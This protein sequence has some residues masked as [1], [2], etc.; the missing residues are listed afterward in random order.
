MKIPS[1][2]RVANALLEMVKDCPR[3]TWFTLQRFWGDR[4]PQA[5]AALTYTA[6]LALVPLT[7]ITVGI[8]SAFPAFDEVMG[9]AQTFAFDNFVP[10]VGQ[11]VQEHLEGF[12]QNAGRLTTLGVLAL[13]ITAVLLLATIEAAFNNI[14]RVRESRP[15]LVRL[16]S[17]WAILTLTPLLFGASISVT[18]QLFSG[19]DFEG[20]I[21]ML[22]Y[23]RGA[24]PLLF[25]W[26]GFSA[27]Y[28]IIPNRPIRGGDA[29]VGGAVAAVLLELS[30]SGFAYYLSAF[31][32]YQTIYGALATIP[33]FLVW[34]YLAWS[35]ILFG[36]VV[37]AALPDWRGG[38]LLGGAEDIHL[39]AR[40]LAV[41]M[42]VLRE[43]A[44]A[45]RS[46][47]TVRRRKLLRHVPVGTVAMDATLGKLRRGRL[48]ERA[49]N[50][51]WLLSR[52]LTRTS[53]YDLAELFGAGL[54]G[55]FDGTAHLEGSE[56]QAM[57]TLLAEV[58]AHHRQVLGRPLA[59]MFTA[60]ETPPGD[61]EDEEEE[62]GAT[63]ADMLAGPP[64]D[65]T[66]ATIMRIDP[67]R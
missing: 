18:N 38:K 64:P 9:R 31:P 66:G 6:L 34:L 7:T 44:V 33:T 48:V 23:T 5:A 57:M 4:C 50:D 36:A 16:L 51:K 35:M 26:V 22:E 28:W 61:G 59:D 62:E 8:L 52:D 58:D 54:V 39:P 19:T 14:W 3:F 37:A 56:Q 67:R 49:A 25:Q 11:V 17:F 1:G 15:W 30:K 43:L 13:L 46:G 10:Q 41:A 20:N 53:L 29:I 55:Q 27:L 45:A 24:F 65:D 47:V 2:E 60:A 32:A 40:H 63:D 42:A 21:P 12:A